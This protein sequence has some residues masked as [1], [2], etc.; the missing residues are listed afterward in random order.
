[1]VAPEDPGPPSP[2]FRGRLF[3]ING[4]P[5][6]SKSAP[7]LRLRLT[8]R[9]DTKGAPTFAGP[10]ILTPDAEGRVAS[11]ALPNAVTKVAKV[12]VDGDGLAV[13]AIGWTGSIE[14]EAQVVLIPSATLGGTVVDPE[15]NP[16][17]GANVNLIAE[18]RA[19]GSYPRPIE[20]FQYSMRYSGQWNTTTNANGRFLLKDVPAGD[21]FVI[22]ASTVQGASGEIRARSTE[23]LDLVIRVQDWRGTMT[24][25]T[26]RVMDDR[27]FPVPGETVH[28]ASETAVT[29][30]DGRFELPVGA[31][32][33]DFMHRQSHA[34][35]WLRSKAG[36]F[37]KVDLD[38]ESRGPYVLRVPTKM[39]SIRGVLKDASGKPVFRAEVCLFDGTRTPNHSAPLERL[40]PRN[41][42]GPCLTDRDG[43]FEIGNLLDRD[44]TLRFIGNDNAL[45]LDVPAV[46]P[47]E[48]KRDFVIPDGHFHRDFSGRCVD[49][50]GRPLAGLRV[51]LRA[52]MQEPSDLPT[53]WGT[54]G[55]TT[56]D[57]RGEFTFE[58]VS[59]K[60]LTLS[61]D[62]DLQNVS[63][64]QSLDIEDVDATGSTPI[65]LNLDCTVHVAQAA[66]SPIASVCFLDA[67]RKKVVLCE[68]RSSSY[69]H[70]RSM[71]PTEDGTYFPCIV[72]QSSRWIQSLDADG[73]VLNETE[74]DL[75]PMTV[76]EVTL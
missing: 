76:N 14:G 22:Q 39:G 21:K 4:T 53:S 63:L 6:T 1:M 75:F 18:L 58:R 26:G 55:V 15:G 30:D 69:Y 66:T 71:R 37:A 8:P 27:G 52:A 32:E 10:I 43:S 23:T 60:G 49:L 57:D 9:A 41:G 45:V 68:L 34:C 40:D 20:D 70:S 2:H 5:I 73:N 72:P 7:G 46:R 16:V 12:A 64:G 59:R 47:N 13:I 38:P 51:S 19:L 56:T 35:L 33:W 54:T 67:E 29:G 62:P 17:P 65:E 74:L 44:Y 50:M 48:P 11:E 25:V 61:F 36:P 31:K 3:D 42:S 28:L 24:T